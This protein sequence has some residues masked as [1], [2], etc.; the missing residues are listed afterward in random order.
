MLEFSGDDYADQSDDISFT[1]GRFIGHHSHILLP[2]YIPVC[3]PGT[4]LDLLMQ[5]DKR[6]PGSIH[7]H[8]NTVYFER[9]RHGNVK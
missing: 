1:S 5:C 6:K 2:V 4:L 8:S 3:V 9:G 7:P